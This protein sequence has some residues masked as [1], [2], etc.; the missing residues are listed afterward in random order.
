MPILYALYSKPL[1]VGVDMVLQ[2][3]RFSASLVGIGFGLFVWL[4]PQPNDMGI[5]VHKFA[6]VMLALYAVARMCSRFDLCH[7]ALYYAAYLFFY[8]QNGFMDMYGGAPSVGTLGVDG[9]NAGT[10]PVIDATAYV[11]F[12]LSLATAMQTATETLD[13][14][15]FG[16][17]A[18]MTMS[19]TGGGGVGGGSPGKTRL[20]QFDEF[21]TVRLTDA[22]F[23]DLEARDRNRRGD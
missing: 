2:R 12:V 10:P 23:D 16:G 6:G 7:K 20:G 22:C 13:G 1:L 5:L 21:E 14:R 3:S 15:C 18:G 11:L 17:Q 9:Y 19:T 4:H 8:G